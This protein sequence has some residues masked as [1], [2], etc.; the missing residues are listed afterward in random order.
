MKDT[1]E[2]SEVNFLQGRTCLLL[3][4]EVIQVCSST[5]LYFYFKD[6]IYL[7]VRDTQREAETQ[8]EGDTGSVWGARR[9]TQSWVSRIRPLSLIH[10]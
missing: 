4:V 6:F 9:G 8:A 1:G 7:F 10:I 5:Y 3:E 2:A